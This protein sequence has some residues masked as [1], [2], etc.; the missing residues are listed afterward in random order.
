M[1]RKIFEQLD[2]DGSGQLTPDELVSSLLARG[3]DPDEVS[4]LFDTLD[5]NHDGVN[6]P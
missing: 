1:A 5:S 2:V 4:K 6:L 3:V